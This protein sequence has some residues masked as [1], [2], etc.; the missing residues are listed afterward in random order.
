MG[1]GGEAVG[2]QCLPWGPGGPSPSLEAPSRFYTKQNKNVLL[3]TKG[4][5]PLKQL[6]G[7]EL[8]NRPIIGSDLHH[9]KT[10]CF[11]KGVLRGL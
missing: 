8:P 3:V 10:L 7:Q 2:Q 1:Q 5:G 4:Y 11:I 6:K 9:K